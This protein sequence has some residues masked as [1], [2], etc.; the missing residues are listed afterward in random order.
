M[1]G[2]RVSLSKAFDTRSDS[3][4]FVSG[5]RS[6]LMATFRRR[7]Q[8]QRG[9]RLVEAD[10]SQFFCKCGH[11]QV[12]ELEVRSHRSKVRFEIVLYRMSNLKW[13]LSLFVLIFHWRVL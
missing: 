11:E 3:P 1:K 5:S 6:G 4:F 12:N 7:A 2:N 8:S 13:F 10:S 9:H